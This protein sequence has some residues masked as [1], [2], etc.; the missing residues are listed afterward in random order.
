MSDPYG[1]IDEA[2]AA[3]D[4]GFQLLL[5]DAIGSGAR[6][7]FVAALSAASDERADLWRLDL[8]Q[9]AGADLGQELP[10][11]MGDLPTHDWMV[12]IEGLEELARA[13]EAARAARSSRRNPTRWRT[14]FRGCGCCSA[15]RRVCPCS[16]RTRPA[17][18]H[19]AHRVRAPWTPP[20]VDTTPG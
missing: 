18:S 12:C 13:G 17:S 1:A 19:A 20:E 15:D 4:G 2:L 10:E 16:R 8:R 11:A 14:R 3:W 9:L 5:V 7:Q 6:E